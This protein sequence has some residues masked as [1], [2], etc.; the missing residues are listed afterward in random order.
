MRAN[1]SGRDWEARAGETSGDT[2]GETSGETSGAGARR[3]LLLAV[4]ADAPAHT[5][6]PITCGP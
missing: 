4:V 2:S 3:A 1:S 6:G 5:G